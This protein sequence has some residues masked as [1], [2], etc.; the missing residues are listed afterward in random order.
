[1]PDSNDQPPQ[2]NAERFTGAMTRFA[3][4]R[5]ITMLVLYVTILVVGFIATI[6]IPL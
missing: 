3:L 6:G 4:N 2:D 5:R 1:M